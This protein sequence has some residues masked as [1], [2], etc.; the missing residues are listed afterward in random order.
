[1]SHYFDNIIITGGSGMIGSQIPFGRKPSSQELDITNATQVNH[2]FEKSKEVTCI[3][4]LASL[5]LR[6]SEKNPMKAIQVNINGTTN[7]VNIAKKLNIPFV[8]VSSGAIFSS[9]NTNLKFSEQSIPSPNCIYGSTKY[10]AEKISLMYDKT[11]VIRTGWLFGGN[12]KSHYKFVE[13]AYTNIVHHQKVICCSNFYGSTT[14]VLDFIYKMKELIQDQQF[15]I[16]HVV[17]EGTS[18]GTDIGE[19][20][21]SLLQKSTTLIDKRLFTDVP[22]CGPLRSATEVL[23]TDHSYKLR[24]WKEALTEYIL[25]LTTRHSNPT[26]FTESKNLWVKRKTCRLCNS[27]NLFEFF[28]G[29]PTPPA[30]HFIKHPTKQDCIPLD[31]GICETCNHIQLLE[32]V[33]PSFL[34][35]NYFYVSSTSAVMTTHLRKSVIQFTTELGLPKDSPILEIGAND[36]VCI[37]ELLDNGFV[38]VVGVDPASNIHSRHKL[39]ILCDYFGSTSKDKI[40]S[41]H[42]Y[43]KL[44]YAFHCMAHIENIQDVFATLYDLLEEGGVFIMEVGYFYEVFRTNQFDVIYHEHIDYHT[45]T[46][47][48]RFSK[49]KGLH[50]F[51]VM[52]NSIQGGSIQFYFT[53]SKDVHVDES[54][55]RTIQKESDMKLFNIQ[56]LHAW[57]FSIKQICTDV[58][59]ILNSFVHAGKKIAAYGASAKSTTFLYQLNLSGNIIKYIVDDNIYK[60]NYY[61]PGLHIPIQSSDALSA[62]RVDYII[63]LSCN[64]ANEIVSK[65]DVYRK[66]GLRIIIPFPEIKII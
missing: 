3:I 7:M 13:Y 25:L 5:N 34:Y 14:Y 19:L 66:T 2:Y 59:C 11:I 6:D 48:D 53:K 30:N 62:D 52:E 12:Q 24:N 16:H 42:P 38:N 39:P 17:N 28:N 29:A 9:E 10:A 41:I 21:V 63:I 43:F 55:P 31:L 56:T 61:S 60:Q 65:L 15:G 20:I 36:G 50:L 47:M 58:N 33:E 18:T 37:K 23:V 40:K 54:V 8:F 1:M 49:Q 4:H 35:S 45:C 57:Q 27:P 22:N 46:S 26:E 32:I 44:I 64:F 51:K